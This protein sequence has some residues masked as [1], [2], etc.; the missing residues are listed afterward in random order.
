MLKKVWVFMISLVLVFSLAPRSYASG[1]GENYYTNKINIRYSI[2]DH[3]YIDLY[4]SEISNLDNN[5][6]KIKVKTVTSSKVETIKMD[7]YL[8]KW[9]GSSW[10]QISSWDG[11]KSNTNSFEK[12]IYYSGTANSKYRVKTTHTVN[13]NGY[14]ESG[15]SVSS[16][17]IIR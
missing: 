9:N 7:V 3:K 1:M 2:Q 15:T 14:T 6:I 5:Q 4:N 13:H 10:I 11:S 16:S 17:I 8:E 12:I